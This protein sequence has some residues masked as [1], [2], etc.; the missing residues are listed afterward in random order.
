MTFGE[1]LQKLRAREGMSQERLAEVL[2]VSRQAVSKWE[3]DET[4]PETEKVIRISEHFSVSLDYL[5]KDAPESSSTQQTAPTPWVVVQAVRLY[6]THSYLLG[7]PLLLYGIYKIGRLLWF[8][9]EHPLI[10]TF[11]LWG[12]LFAIHSNISLDAL[13]LCLTGI[14][15]LLWGRSRQKAIRWHHA[16]WPL[17][18]FGGARLIAEELWRFLFL[19]IASGL[20]KP[21]TEH[22]VEIFAQRYGI[23]YLYPALFLLAGIVII[24]IG[25]RVQQKERGR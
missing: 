6:Q 20:G 19:R 7:L 10:S 15:M 1:K 17:A 8:D 13:C 5:L 22:L 3:R 11:G 16:G 2:G 14:W 18:L 21:Y 23:N 4:L 24:L 12:Y 25:R 9:S